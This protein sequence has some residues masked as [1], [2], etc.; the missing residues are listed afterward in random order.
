MQWRTYE[1]TNVRIFLI[2]VFKLISNSRIGSDRWFFF[3][4]QICELVSFVE[5]LKFLQRRWNNLLYI[6]RGQIEILRTDGASERENRKLAAQEKPSQ[7]G[8]ALCS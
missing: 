6:R 5:R 1:S 7:F 2:R 8:R 3:F 4:A